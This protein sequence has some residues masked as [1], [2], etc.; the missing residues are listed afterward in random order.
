MSHELRTPM[1][2]IIGMA[3]LASQTT[4]PD[5][6]RHYLEVLKRSADSLLVVINDVLDFSRIEAGKLDLCLMPFDLEQC[7][8][9]CLAPLENLAC[10][11]GLSFQMDIARDVPARVVGDPGRLRQ[12]LVNLVGNAIKFTQAGQIRLALTVACSEGG[13]ITLRFAVQDTG[14]GI[15]AQ[16]QA[17]IF[18]AFEQ[19]D[20]Y[21]VRRQGGSGLGLAISRQLVELMGGAIGVQSDVGSGST[22]HF[23]A[24]FGVEPASE[25]AGSREDQLPSE[26]GQ[27][28]LISG[29]KGQQE[30]LEG[31]LRGW[32]L[33]VTTARNSA[34][35]DQA[36]AEARRSQVGFQLVF[37]DATVEDLD[38]FATSRWLRQQGECSQAVIAVYSS[39]GL[40]GDAG[41]CRGEGADVYLAGSID[42]ATFRRVIA[43]A[44]L[45]CQGRADEKPLTRHN[46]QVPAAVLTVLLVEDNPVNQEVARTV[47]ESWGHRVLVAS[48]GAEALAI[49]PAQPCDLVL[50]DVQMPEMDGL[51]TT[52]RLRRAEEA[53]GKRVPIIAM[54]AHA[55]DCDRQACLGAGMDGYVCKPVRPE[56]LQL[57][58]SR[59]MAV[60]EGKGRQT[61]S[62]VHE[63]RDVW[64]LQTALG[65]VQQ[66]R[67][68][69]GRMISRYLDHEPGGQ[70]RVELAV[71]QRQWQPLK[72]WAHT[73]KSTLGILGAVRAHALAVKVDDL[74]TQQN[75]EAAGECF[76]RLC[77]EL[78]QLRGRLKS[79]LEENEH[80]SVGGGR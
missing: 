77:G 30:R 79:W 3:D 72:E 7:L 10:R 34:T 40:R 23:T 20:P 36:M 21:Q 22:F 71:A 58:I 31:M 47:L 1:N 46:D 28:L 41:R 73:A 33:T 19:G 59:T 62:V 66:D 60:C 45:N 17:R 14:P 51:E 50:M 11:K 78:D 53:T 56:V 25:A 54:T 12:V 80:A 26:I 42:G 48:S 8:S 32:G 24:R 69:L 61:V 49:Y 55:R 5:K 9:T 39:A 38:V 37:L 16:D 65:Y 70:Q 6:Q 44:Y 4:E 57:A 75:H 15:S 63:S 13:N 68:L 74:C 27:A 52:T 29:L 43:T 35:L 18:Q 67:A 64:D 76:G 2:G